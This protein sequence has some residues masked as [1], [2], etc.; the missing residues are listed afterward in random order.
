[1]TEEVGKPLIKVESII[2]RIPEIL[3]VLSLIITGAAVV[4]GI[5]KDWYLISESFAT[6]GTIAGPISFVEIFALWMPPIR[7]SN[8][9]S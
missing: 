8:N 3:L 6:L 2:Q 7:S 9:N 4:D 1:M 5:N